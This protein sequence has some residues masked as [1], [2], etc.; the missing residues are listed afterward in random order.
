MIGKEQKRIAYK[1]LPEELREKISSNENIERVEGITNKFS[2][3]EDQSNILDYEIL[4]VMIGLESDKEFIANISKR[5]NIEENKALE[6]FKEADEK[7]F[8]EVRDLIPKS[9]DS[10]KSETRSQSLTK[11]ANND[12]QPAD[13]QSQP[14]T[15]PQKPP[16]TQTPSYGAPQKS[17]QPAIERS[18]WW[19]Q[20]QNVEHGAQNVEHGTS[21]TRQTMS[22][23][24]KTSGDLRSTASD[25]GQVNKDIEF[26]DLRQNHVAQNVEHRTSSTRQTMN[27][28]R[29]TKNTP[30]VPE[31]APE[32]ELTKRND[33]QRTM[34]EERG[35]MN[36]LQ[37]SRDSQQNVQKV[38]SDD[39]RATIIEQ[40][41]AQEPVVFNEP[42]GQR[43]ATI[44]ERAV[45]SISKPKP[46]P[47]IID[48]KLAEISKSEEEWQKRKEEIGGDTVIKS[49]YPPG[50]DPYRETLK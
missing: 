21:N 44:L 47:T 25:L 42:R 50:Q 39:N 18:K 26:H 35:I 31:I 2:L 11:Q 46:E 6:I 5:L 22:D 29:L 33:E 9:G 8:K 17:T 34:N 30:S 48:K 27:D 10:K 32:M 45:P 40:R 36:N 28:G 37:N 3:N 1:K 20:Q 23:E 19:E 13:N 16:S 12:P 24:R 43:K 41:L 7:I 4:L 14:L 15:S 38:V 49:S